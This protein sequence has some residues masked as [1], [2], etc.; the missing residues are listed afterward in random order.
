MRDTHGR[1][2]GRHRLELLSDSQRRQSWL[3]IYSNSSQ[4][5]QQ[6]NALKRDLQCEISQGKVAL[7]GLGSPI[8]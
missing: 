8:K 7:L 3:Q 4:I 2:K 5:N 1:N 6:Y